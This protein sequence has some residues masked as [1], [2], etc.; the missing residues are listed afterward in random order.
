M[1]DAPTVTSAG[2]NAANFMMNVSAFS[3]RPRSPSRNR[4]IVRSPDM[5]FSIAV[6]LSAPDT[7][8]ANVT[9]L[10]LAASANWARAC[11]VSAS[12]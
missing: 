1:N 12:A 9:N 8:T 3:A 11:A 7:R 6:I 4:S 5:A 10:V 2:P